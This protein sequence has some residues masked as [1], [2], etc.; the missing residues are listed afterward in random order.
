[1]VGEIYT[2]R[3]T[4]REGEKNK[5]QGHSINTG[6]WHKYEARAQVFQVAS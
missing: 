1:M 3:Q 6:L 2:N 4:K 5:K